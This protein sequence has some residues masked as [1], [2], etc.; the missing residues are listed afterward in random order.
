MTDCCWSY[1]DLKQQWHQLCNKLQTF[2][3]TNSLFALERHKHWY[4]QSLSHT[5]LPLVGELVLIHLVFSPH[6]ITMSNGLYFTTVVSCFFLFSTPNLCGHWTD[7]NQ[8]WTHSHL[9]M[10]FEK[11]GLNSTGIYPPRA[12]GKNHFF[13]ANFELWPRICPQRNMISK[14][15]KKLVRDSHT[16]PHIWWTLVQKGLR[17]V[18]EC[19]PTLPNFPTGRL[20]VLP[21]G[22]YITDS[23]QALAR[24][25]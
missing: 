9:W 2:L 13:V 21:H 6:S 4:R 3:V 14:I 8:T 7:L 18:G 5:A 22:R 24:V 25:M 16:C 12:E 10:L 1:P 23:R 11:F 19:L 17:T 20:P 15:K